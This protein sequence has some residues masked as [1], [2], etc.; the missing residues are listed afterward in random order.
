MILCILL[1]FE[2]KM[3]MLVEYGAEIVL[4]NPH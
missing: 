4:R 1:Y 3:A 2:N